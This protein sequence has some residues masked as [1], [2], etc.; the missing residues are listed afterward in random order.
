MKTQI[1]LGTVLLALPLLTATLAQ[2]KE[3]PFTVYLDGKKIGQ[4]SFVLSESGEEREMTS[5]ANFNVKVLFINAYRY[6]HVAREKWRGDCLT[7]LDAK[8]EENKEVTVVKGKLDGSNFMVDVPVAKKAKPQQQLP[9]CVMT[10]PYWNAA[11]LSQQHLL[12]PQTGEWLDVKIRSLGKD[13]IEVRG[14]QVDAEHF[15]LEATK[16]KIDLWYSADKEWLALTS[17]T[18]EGYVITYKLR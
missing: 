4:H 16:M 8:T 12:N 17:T 13:T 18:P 9:A 2:A 11:M 14:K 15:K 6:Q 10:F 1:K 7:S 5:T 3:W